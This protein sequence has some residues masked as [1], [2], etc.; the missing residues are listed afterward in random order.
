MKIIELEQRLKQNKLDSLYYLYGEEVFL[1]EQCLNKIKKL[2]GPLVEGI[3]YIKIDITNIDS[4]IDNIEVPTFGYEKKLVVVRDSGLFVKQKKTKG[5]KSTKSE[6]TDE[7]KEVDKSIKY[8]DYIEKHLEEI[9]ETTVLV[10]I[11]KEDGKNAL[12]KVLTKNGIEC[13]FTLQKPEELVNRILYFSNAYG[14]NINR[15]TASYF[16]QSCGQEMLPLINELRKQIEYAGKGGTI[17]KENIDDLACKQIDA[18]I[19]DITDSLGSHNVKR[20]LQI[21]DD[22][23]YLKE[24]IQKVLLTI[25]GHFKKIYFTKT[26]LREKMSVSE[27]LGLSEKTAFLEKKYI[28]QSKYFEEK[29]LRRII[30]EFI[31]LDYKYKTGAIDVNLGLESILCAYCS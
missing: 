27:I 30:Q 17:T 14:V 19:F 16:V 6:K 7:E 29:T 8:S 3:N 10:F 23:L 12:S 11:E 13:N 28:A 26:A 9:K 24:P 31:D 4:L 22:L 2:F 21:L 5:K 15:N 20:A 18:Y 1:L 25:Y